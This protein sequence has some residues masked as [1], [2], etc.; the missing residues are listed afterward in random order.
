MEFLAVGFGGFLLLPELRLD[1]FAFDGVA[2][3]AGQ[4][5]AVHLALDEI[6]L[7]AVPDGV[8]GELF[9]GQSGQD[10]DGHV[11]RLGENGLERPESP[12]VGEIEVQQDQVDVV[13]LQAGKPLAEVLDPD[14]LVDAVG[15]FVRHQLNQPAV[16]G[17]IFHKQNLE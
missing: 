17:V 9:V 4:Q 8:D 5:P 1:A 12:A 2:D 10:D 3:G 16:A 6:I 13:T 15:L 7:R 14:H 11:G